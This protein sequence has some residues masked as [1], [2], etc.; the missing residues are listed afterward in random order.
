MREVLREAANELPDTVFVRRAKAIIEHAAINFS[1]LED[2]LT[3][4]AYE[5]L[6][7]LEEEGEI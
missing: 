5:S 7:A 4:D 3:R 6:L 2:F 1:W